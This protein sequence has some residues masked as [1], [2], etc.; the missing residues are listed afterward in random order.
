MRPAIV[1]A[2]VVVVCAC[3]RASGGS[4]DA[5]GAGTA[6]AEQPVASAPADSLQG[7]V[8]IVGLDAAPQVTLALDDGSPAVT[9]VGTPSLRK[10]AGLRVA[11]VGVRAGRQLTV[12]R[13]VV[14]S[15]N[16]IPATDGM[17]AADGGVIT[18]VTADGSRHPLVSPS[19]ALRA[20]VGHRVWI[21]GPLS[22]AAVAY[23]VIE[24]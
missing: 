13:F 2:A 5:G 1:L 11:V 24:E 18:L 14:I 16:G 22:S 23:G 8:R 7:M 15:A 17:L 20:A 19:P 6:A 12:S 10:L 9:L 3:H 4:G 21:S